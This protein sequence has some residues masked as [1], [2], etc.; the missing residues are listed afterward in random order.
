MNLNEVAYSPDIVWI[1]YGADHYD[2]A[3]FKPINYTDPG[4]VLNNKPWGGLWGCPE[5]SKR[6]WGDWCRREQFNTQS[7][8]H[9]FRF[10]LSPDAKIYVIDNEQDLVN[11]STSMRL[12]YL[13]CQG[14]YSIDFERLLNEGYD[15][16]YVTDNALW[17]RW[18][19][20][21]NRNIVGLNSWDVESI[22]VFNPDVIIPLEVN[23]ETPGTEE[24]NNY[25]EKQDTMK[26][27]LN[28]SALRNFVMETVSKALM[29]ISEDEGWREKLTRANDLFRSRY[30]NSVKLGHHPMPGEEGFVDYKGDLDTLMKG[31]ADDFNN[32]F[33]YDNGTEHYGLDAD[34]ID[35]VIVSKNYGTDAP[36]SADDKPGFWMTPRATNGTNSSMYPRVS[37]YP[38]T[39]QTFGMGKVPK[40]YSPEF[41]DAIIKGNRAIA[42]QMNPKR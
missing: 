21:P 42:Q 22:C 35:P 34:D 32:E 11:I 36:P 30:D 17:M 5:N 27:T 26:M 16:I 13:V 6:G 37:A 29:S 40:E 31:V 18:F 38:R 4:A 15:G 39:A 23:F 20:G 24:K 8:E 12:A 2:P 25:G 33:G 41:R 3:K 10:R 19:H 14:Y 1:S 28:E 9:S 7:L